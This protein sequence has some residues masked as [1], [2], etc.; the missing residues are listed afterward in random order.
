MKMSEKGNWVVMWQWLVSDYRY[1][2]NTLVIL[3][4]KEL[5][6][7]EN[8]KVRLYQFYLKWTQGTKCLSTDITTLVLHSLR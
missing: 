6:E 7:D 1:R 8:A 2:P 5:K 4:G 3:Y